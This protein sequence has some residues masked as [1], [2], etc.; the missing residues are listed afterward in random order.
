MQIDDPG[1]E[2]L[3]ESLSVAGSADGTFIPPQPNNAVE[4]STSEYTSI[5]EMN[6]S[7]PEISEA[8]GTTVQVLNNQRAPPKQHYYEQIERKTD[9]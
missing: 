5:T 7:Q 2:G 4:S 3:Y 6:N 9:P 1:P 8:N